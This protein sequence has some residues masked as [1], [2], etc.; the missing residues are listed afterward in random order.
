MRQDD[1]QLIDR[2]RAT[3]KLSPFGARV[4]LALIRDPNLSRLSLAE[5][6][7]GA[8]PKALQVAGPDD[9]TLAPHVHEARHRLRACGI[10]IETVY[11]RGWHI[12]KPDLDRLKQVLGLEP[13]C[14]A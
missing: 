9:N 10:R 8:G 3:F 11:R 13:A 2:I 14:A 12:A 6:L 4:V 5:A 1:T 7:Y